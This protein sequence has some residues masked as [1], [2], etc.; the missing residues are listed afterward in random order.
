MDSV[1]ATRPGL[2]WRVV[3]ATAFSWLSFV[4]MTLLAVWN[5][6]R[7]GA[8]L[9]DYVLA[10]VPYVQ[11]IDHWNYWIWLLAWI[12]GIAVFLVREP[13]V[14]VRLMAASGICSLLRGVCIV[15]TGL[16]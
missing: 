11:R 5:E 14:Y 10:A 9:H 7:P 1:A 6:G 4:V 8:P 12:P 15:A 2:A 3:L 13:A 16:G